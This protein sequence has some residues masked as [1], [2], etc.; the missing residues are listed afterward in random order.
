MCAELIP[1]VCV[2]A[3]VGFNPFSH[4]SISSPAVDA[5]IEE[6]FVR[7]ELSDNF[8]FY[9]SHYDSFEGVDNWAKTSLELHKDDRVCWVHVVA[10][11]SFLSQQ[12]PMTYTLGELELAVTHDELWNAAQL[13]MT[14]DGKMHGFMRMYWAKKVNLRCGALILIGALF[15]CDSRSSNGPKHPNKRFDSLFISM[16]STRSMGETQMDTLDACGRYAASMIK[17]GVSE[18]S[19]ERCDT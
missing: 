8:C 17:G 7:R 15:C 13:Q 3:R 5:F 6:S 18:K 4:S 14:R 12:R 19:L 16:T 9:N 1:N 11:H 2:Y 10:S